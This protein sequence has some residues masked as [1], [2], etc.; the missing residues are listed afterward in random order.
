MR[1]KHRVRQGIVNYLLSFILMLSVVVIV[2]GG[3]GKWS[4]ASRRAVI[5][6][7]DRT[8]YFYHLKN[9]IEQSAADIGKPFGLDLDVISGVFKTSEVKSDVLKTFDQ[10]LYNKKE[11]I[12][13]GYIENRIRSNVEKKEGKLNEK[14]LASLGAYM[15]KLQKMYLEELHFPTEKQMVTII[16]KTDKLAWIAIPLAVL[17]GFFSAFYLIVSRHYAYHGLRFVVYGLIGAGAL[18][19]VGFS[20]LVSN[21]SFYEYNLTDSFMKDYYGY[22]VGHVMFIEVVY[23]IGILVLGLIGIFLAYRQKYAVRR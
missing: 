2:A 19:T 14:Q 12:D 20:A 16:T 3:V 8:H 1:H 18:I 10:R 9:E 23:G 4:F 13:I 7:G 22:Y 11:I 17:I 21:G 6:A 5:H 15:R